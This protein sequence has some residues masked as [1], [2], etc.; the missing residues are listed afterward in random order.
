MN[1][2]VDVREH[3]LLER[4]STLPII[5]TEIKV[6]S[7]QLLIGDI[8]LRTQEGKE[9]VL[10]ERKSLSDLLASIKDGRYKEQ[11]HRLTHTSGLIPHNIVYI[12]EGALSTLRSPTDKKLVYSAITSLSFFKGFSVFR[13][14]T[15]MET[16]EIIHAMA[17]KIQ[18]DYSLPR[19]PS[20]EPLEKV[21][22]NRPCDMGV[23][24]STF[25]KKARKDNITP[26]NIGEIFLCQIPG[27]SSTIA[28]EILRH[29]DGSFSTLLHEIKTNKD[30]TKGILN[31]I[32][33]DCVGDKKRKLSSSVIASLEKYLI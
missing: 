15:I 12:I 26:E 32:Y 29:F 1:I 5:N 20:E 25:V 9:L 16:A 13:T 18:K 6:Q 31:T 7:E 33:M 3:S 2:I 17:H 30:K 10:F 23:S 22:L 8:L 19:E 14:N 28:T 21:E 4:L 27:I 24:Y 11:S